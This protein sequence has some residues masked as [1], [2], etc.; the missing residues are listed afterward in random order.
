LTN[1]LT[2]LQF[3]AAEQEDLWGHLSVQ[4]HEEPS[5]PKDISVKSVMDTWTLQMGFPVVKRNYQDKT[6]TA[7][8]TRKKLPYEALVRSRLAIMRR[9]TAGGFLKPSTHQGAVLTRLTVSSG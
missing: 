4:G 8:V 7:T 2:D 3:A 9:N 1:F 5:Q 6:A